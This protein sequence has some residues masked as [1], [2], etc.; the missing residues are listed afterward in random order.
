MFTKKSSNE[1]SY[2]HKINNDQ[3]NMKLFDDSSF[4]SSTL[5]QQIELLDNCIKNK[6]SL[7]AVLKSLNLSYDN[8]QY[9]IDRKPILLDSQYYTL[10]DFAEKTNGIPVVSFF[11]GAGGLDLGFEAAGFSHTILIEKNPLFCETL[12]FNRPH[13]DIC[14]GDVSNSQSMI[15]LL[16]KR[17]GNTN[18]FEGIFIGGPP[19]Q[20]FSIASNQRFNKN[21]ENFKRTGFAHETNGNL[22][23]DYI[24]LIERFRP[25]VFL[26]ENVPGLID[27]DGGE[28]LERAYRKLEKCGYQIQEPL[29]L[30]ADYHFV[31][32]QRT[33]LFIIGN[34]SNKDFFP[35]KASQHSLSVGPVFELSLEGVENHVTREH[36]AESVLRYMM[37]N[38]GNRDKLGRV[39][40]LDPLLPSK[41][42][43]AGGSAGGG[44]SHLHPYIPR[45]LSVRESARIQT[46]P[47]NY[48]FVGSVARQFTQVGNAVP[49]VL[50]AQLAHAIYKSFYQ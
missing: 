6:K 45:T 22:L 4:L 35:P 16:S 11:S 29:I 44:R 30:K 31:P 33:R 42:V 34:R 43:I 36:S 10:S 18:K 17:I 21:G 23:F 37:L 48:I 5:K 25:R 20:P 3:Y 26:I 8:L 27:V 38:Y 46:F 12:K 47:D 32:Q 28:Q 40:R 41:T 24:E 19:C 2:K 9:K 7:A 49:P 14:S 1:L 13:W 15:E 39:D 50:G